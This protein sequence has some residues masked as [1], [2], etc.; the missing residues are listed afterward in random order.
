[1]AL[2]TPPPIGQQCGPPLVRLLLQA[3]TMHPLGTVARC[4]ASHLVHTGGGGPGATEGQGAESGPASVRAAS[5]QAVLAWTL[6]A[7]CS[8]WSWTRADRIPGAAPCPLCS[9]HGME[10][11]T[12]CP[13]LVVR[14]A[15]PFSRWKETSTYGSLGNLEFLGANALSALTGN[16]AGPMP[17]CK[18]WAWLFTTLTMMHKQLPGASEECSGHWAT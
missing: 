2:S 14:V 10:A 9:S 7:T 1:M 15:K 12:N 18:T 4:V 6:A 11:V 17:A 8:G 5:G 3:G 13:V 16:F